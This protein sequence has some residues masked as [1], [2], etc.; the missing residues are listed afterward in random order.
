[1]TP[2]LFGRLQTRVVLLSVLGL[3]WSI[4]IG[5]AVAA[6]ADASYRDAVGAGVRAVVVALVVGLGWEL[7]YHGLQQIRWEKDWPTLFGLLTGLNEGLV[8][9]LLLDASVLGDPVPLDAFLL[10]FSTLW[11]LVWAVANGPLVIIAPRW[12]YRGGRFV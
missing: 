6:I 3:T 2:T 7:V 10:H 5:P 12:R 11:I 9:F 1:M 4:V 8:V